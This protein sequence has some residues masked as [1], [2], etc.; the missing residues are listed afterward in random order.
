MNELI[1]YESFIDWSSGVPVVKHKEMLPKEVI[2]DVATAAVSRPYERTEEEVF[3]NID[4]HFEGMT[5]AEVMNIRLARKAAQG[6]LPSYNALS[7]RILGKPKQAVES[8]KVEMNYADYL[9]RVSEEEDVDNIIEAT[10]NDPDKPGTI[11]ENTSVIS[12]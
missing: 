2:R 11:P 9:D 7:D 3:L 12:E 6:D 5:N 8:I 1:T 10:I 4:P